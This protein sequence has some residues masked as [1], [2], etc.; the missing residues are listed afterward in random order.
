MSEGRIV[1][2]RRENRPEVLYIVID[3]PKALNALTEEMQIDLIEKLREARDDK[4]V[5]CV[6]LMTL[7]RL[8]SRRVRSRVG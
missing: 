4:S 7:P 5:R 3:N 6:V 1:A 8:Y 2:R